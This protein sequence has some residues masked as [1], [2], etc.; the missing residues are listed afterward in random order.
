M[1]TFDPDVFGEGGKPERSIR[2]YVENMS[3]MLKALH[4]MFNCFCGVSGC[5]HLL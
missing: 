2:K 4:S 1:V 5:Q 3:I